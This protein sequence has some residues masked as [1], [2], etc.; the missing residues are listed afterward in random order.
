MFFVILVISI[1]CFAVDIFCVYWFKHAFNL[2][3]AFTAFETNS[4]ESVEFLETYLNWKLLGIYLVF[5]LL[6]IF[7]WLKITLKVPSKIYYAFLA[8]CLF[9]FINFAIHIRTIYK[10]G[11]YYWARPEISYI[12][13]LGF[14]TKL[15]FVS[16]EIESM[17]QAVQKLKTQLRS[18]QIDIQTES[19]TNIANFALIIGE[20]TQRGHMQLYGYPKPNTPNLIK[21]QQQGNLFV[22][23]DVISPHAQTN[24]SL[25]T[26][27]TFANYE[28][29]KTPWYQQANLVSIVQTQYPTYWF[30]NQE[31]PI[32]PYPPS[33]IGSL[34]QYSNFVA[35]QYTGFD[36]RLLQ[37]F[38]SANITSQKGFYVFHLMGTHGT[39][40]SRYPKAFELFPIP[41]FN[42]HQR[43]IT[44]YDNAIFYNDYI[45]SEI[46]KRFASKDALVLYFSD[47]GEEVHELGEFVG[48]G[49]NPA[50]RFQLEIPM[51]IYVSDIFKQKHP[52]IVQKIQASLNRPYMTDDLIHTILDLLGIKT[53]ESQSSRSI[54]SKDFDTKRKRMIGNQDYDKDL[55]GQKA[56]R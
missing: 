50:S 44:Q 28:N 46:F 42:T 23:T 21:L 32:Y 15:H 29:A 35:E 30:S 36:E 54:V 45:V 34:A 38:D 4:K 10:P 55:K 5:I 53:A 6:S 12:T 47:H 52:E 33:L 11:Y 39:Y 16:K 13:P 24:L 9:G 26:V 25:Q 48:H 37:A 19:K 2:N 49:S 56:L 20:S 1:I 43:R 31:P 18:T 40:Q 7:Y 22:F 8:F 51:M 27:L 41:A 14:A 3:M 17:L